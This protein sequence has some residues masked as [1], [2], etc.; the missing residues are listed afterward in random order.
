VTA[1]YN[2]ISPHAAAWLRNLIAAGLVPAGDVDERSICDVQPIDLR[3]YRQCHFFAGIGGWARAATIAGW[4]DDRE[5][6]TGSCPCQP[7]SVAGSGA[8][9]AD[10]RHLWPE[11]FRLIRA[12]RPAVVMGEQ[13]AAA[14]GRGWWDAV[15]D[16][17][18]G[19]G[20]ACRAVDVPA[21]ALGAPHIRHRLWFVADAG[22]GELRQ[23]PRRGCGQDRPGAPQPGEHG[24]TWPVADAGRAGLSLPERQALLGAGRRE[25]G[26]ATPG[27]GWWAAEPDV[28]R[29]AHGI[30]GRVGALRAL[31]NAIV[32][33][34][35]AEVIGAYLETVS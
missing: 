14:A 24:A 23:Q 7:W 34:V 13:V 19:V 1:Y 6:W 18:E 21:V 17:L 25:E 15:A 31:G 20:Y 30:P 11:W 32:P 28:G 5:L 9:A 27:G 33:Q 26:P 3:N 2:E 29:V 35:A 16:D 4:P 12:A 22:G 10:A 8:G